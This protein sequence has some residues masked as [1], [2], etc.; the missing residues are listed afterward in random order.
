METKDK[1]FPLTTAQRA[2]CASLTRA[3]QRCA[4]E[5]VY[6]WD[7][8]G[9]ITAVNGKQVG[10]VAHDDVA[11]GIPMELV[12]QIDVYSGDGWGDATSDDPLSALPVIS[13]ATSTEDT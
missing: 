9:T 2:A 10:A 8:Y 4:R 3:L 13:G 12:D 7:Y 6:L 11:S 1:L 5:G